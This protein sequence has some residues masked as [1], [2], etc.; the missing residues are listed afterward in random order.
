MFETASPTSAASSLFRHVER[1]DFRDKPFVVLGDDRLTYGA[2]RN[3]MA[4]T[5]GL[6]RECGIGPGD[7]I[8]I[9]SVHEIEVIA[10]YLAALRS[11][12][13]AALID[14]HSSLE[15]T[16]NLV[17]AAEAKA[18]F[19]DENLID[20]ARFTEDLL[21]GGRVFGMASGG[22]CA[23]G[24]WGA[25]A[26][27]A[28]LATSYPRLL[29]RYQPVSLP[30]TLPGDT[31]AFILFTSGTT[32]R[33]KGV[34][35]THGAMTMHFQTMHRQYGYGPDS[36]ILN[37]LPLH[38]SDGINHGAANVLAAGATLFRTGPFTVQRLPEIL[39]MVKQHR[40]TH[41][42]T[43]PTVLALMARLGDEFSDAFRTEDFRF[44]SSTAGPLDE[45][46][47]RAFESRF[48]TMV[49]NSY[50]LT[51]TICEGFY[52]GPTPETRRI[53]TI[54][55]PIDI[56]VRLLGENG[57]D[58][59]EGAMGEIVLRGDCVMKGYYKAPEETAA[60]LR[61]GWLYT[62]D[63][64]I[65]DAD[66][67]YS[68]VGRKKN[69]IITGGLNVYPEDV[70]R[71]IS[72]MPGIADVVTVGMPDETWGERV[73][74]CVVAN[75]SGTVS[76]EDV[77]AYCRTKL[78]KEKIPSEVLVLEE[79]PRGPAGKVALPEVK[80]IIARSRAPSPLRSELPVHG[81]KESIAV[82]VLEL[83]A[84]S[85]NMPVAELSLDSQPETTSGWTSLAHVGYLVA[86]ESEFGITIPPIDMLSINT[87]GDAVRFIERVS[88]G[89][90]PQHAAGR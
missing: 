13:T 7:R 30:A 51:E 5:A 79:L 54:G 56:D 64:A 90:S 27:G 47:W 21:P 74:S 85:F 39:G 4:R 57:E 78:S 20:G 71:V 81:P 88:S 41:K 33:P 6:F 15:E 24:R 25:D 80:G 60:V 37:G 59:P 75:Q 87:I 65:R 34:E 58:V 40:I 89:Q 52:C 46:L 17:R 42:I 18:L 72:R 2:L 70:S 1:E 84:D 29:H 26:A 83:A 12:V 14:P 73:V 76:G 49:V 10:L 22:A 16:G 69:V 61:E 31:S 9:C 3:V 62:G 32:S 45:K 38:H 86:L 66:G 48:G 67:F 35:V 43:V 77:I 11:G 55:K 68:V 44:V 28:G 23:D 53:G 82:R 8:V 19:L 50:G 63:L 36:R